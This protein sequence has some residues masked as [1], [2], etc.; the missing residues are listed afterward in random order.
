VVASNAPA[1]IDRFLTWQEPV[2][3][4]FGH[5]A[6]RGAFRRY[7]LGLLS[8]TPRKSMSAMLARV[9][10]PGQLSG[11]SASTFPVVY[12]AQQRWAIEQPYQELKS[13][14]GLDHLEGRSWPGW[15][16]HAVLTALATPSCRSNG[17]ANSHAHSPCRACA[18]SRRRSSRH[19][20]W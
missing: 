5:R 16:R 2:E 20:S 12:L 10:D 14:L 8:D 11:A 3:R 9:S 7:R 6:Q 17:S 15:Q 18:P 1:W 4:A 19:I 13:E